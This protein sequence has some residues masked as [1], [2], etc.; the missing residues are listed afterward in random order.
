MDKKIKIAYLIYAT[1]NS[2]GMQ[3]VLSNKVNILSQHPAYQ[4]YIIT[5][6]Q[7][8][9]PSYFT[10][11]DNVTQ[12]DLGINYHKYRNGFFIIKLVDFFCKQRIHRKKLENTLRA[13]DIDITIS[14]YGN[15][16]MFLPFLKDRSKKIFELHF[17]MNFRKIMDENLHRN[18]LY[19]LSTLYRRYMELRAI[20]YY[21]AFVVLTNED[22]EQ[23]IKYVKR[24]IIVIPNFIIGGNTKSSL[25]N[26][27][28]VA[29]GNLD[30]VKG[31]D[32]L[33]SAWSLIS[34]DNP[35]W[36]LHIYGCGYLKDA[37]LKQIISMGVENTVTIHPPTKNIAAVYESSSI[38]VLSSRSEGFPMVLLEAMDKG[39]AVVAFACKC[40]PKDIVNNA[41][42]GFL[43]SEGNIQGL[44]DTISMLMNDFKLRRK[45][46]ANAYAMVHERFNAKKVM[47]QWYDL[48]EKILAN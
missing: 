33:I 40:G 44:A 23:W 5:T 15:E 41:E 29:V 7:D 10:I 11:H 1:N 3:R 25:S 24:P 14:M 46:G 20:N 39:L 22:R 12:I 27:I 36:N 21:D 43:V 35:E 28:V 18:L 31:F 34:H 13:L 9:R 30:V 16:T 45:I 8:N 48:F 4:I 6:D 17:S 19:R 37:L 32:R 47:E 38:F 42:N 2:G 26:K